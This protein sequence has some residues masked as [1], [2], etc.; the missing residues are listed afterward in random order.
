MLEVDAVAEVLGA[1]E[2]GAD[3]GDA[4]LG[5]G[6]VVFAGEG[7]HQRDALEAEEV[8]EWVLVNGRGHVEDA[9][10]P[11]LRVKGIVWSR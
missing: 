8:G 7:P 2:E 1:V 9:P 3:L 5:E 6:G 10:H 11:D 4:G